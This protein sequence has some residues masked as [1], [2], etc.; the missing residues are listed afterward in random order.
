MAETLDEQLDELV[1]QNWGLVYQLYARAE[2]VRK[3]LLEESAAAVAEHGLLTENNLSANLIKSS[4]KNWYLSLS[5]GEYDYVSYVQVEVETKSPRLGVRVLT[6]FKPGLGGRYA[7]VKDGVSGELREKYG[8]DFDGSSSN[9]IVLDVHLTGDHRHLP[10]R[11][12]MEV[13]RQLPMALA[14][15]DVVA[16]RTDGERV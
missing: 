5:H 13:E 2:Q 7:E 16:E 10:G 4:S 15:R 1:L 8:P 12:V 11:I 3:K 14:I 9:A 6:G